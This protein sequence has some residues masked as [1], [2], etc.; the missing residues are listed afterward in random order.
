[1]SGPSQGAKKIIM[2]ALTLVSPSPRP[3]QSLVEGALQNELRLLE[4]GLRRREQRLQGFEARYGLS[5]ADFI[6]RYENDALEETL[7]CAEWVDEYRLRARLLEKADALRAIR[8][9][10]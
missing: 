3:L 5:T 4:A 8:F 6:Q 2:A 7:E 9:A 1:V 10:D